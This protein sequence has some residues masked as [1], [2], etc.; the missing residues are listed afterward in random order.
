MKLQL[1]TSHLYVIAFSHKKLSLQLIGKL[2]LDPSS[3]SYVALLEQI[4]THFDATEIMHISTCNR[5]E[6]YIVSKKNISKSDA[7]YFF[8]QF[9]TLLN[10]AEKDKLSQ[11]IFKKD[12]RAVKYI[13]EVASSLQ[14]MVVGEREIITQIRHAY[15]HCQ[16]LRLTGDLLRLVIKKSIE[17]GKE[18]FTH[19][20]IAKNPVSVA[21]LAARALKQHHIPINARV[22]LIG[23]GI[24]MQTFMKY[25]HQPSYQYTFISR[26]KEHSHRLQN[27][28]GG[29]FMSLSELEQLAQL[30]TDILIVCTAS[31][32]PIVNTSL[33][34]KIFS[35]QSHPI[36]VDLSNPSNV[37]TEV[38]T[39]P[40]V[41]YIDIQSLKKQARDNLLRR[42]QSIADAQQIIQ[43]NLEEFMLV[44]KERCIENVIKEIPEE[45][46]QYKQ[47]ALNEVFRKQI[48][49]LQDAHK[50]I[51]IEILDYIENKYNAV[52]YKKLKSILS[53]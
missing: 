20:D 33:Y 17:T 8:Q 19:T 35:N 18:I 24:T 29:Q 13:M 22:T 50:E 38:Y 10:P 6:F 37:S 44:F 45:F 23:S 51:V 7:Q 53:Q 15:E 11:L 40:Q 9:Y 46:K 2:Y 34:H 28:Y 1:H 5:C 4:K 26:R 14:S 3:P 39:Q 32:V 27:K 41:T 21:S 43:K 25:F 12:E 31:P 52:T 48:D 49:K 36:I 42:K 16:S 30:P 47:K